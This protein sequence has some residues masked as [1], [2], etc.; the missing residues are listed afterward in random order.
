MIRLA[1]VLYTYLGCGT[2][3]NIKITKDAIKT[4]LINCT[5]SL[6]NSARYKIPNITRK[7][8]IRK[9]VY[10]L[11]LWKIWSYGFKKYTSRDE[12]TIGQGRHS[13]NTYSLPLP[14]ISRKD[15]LFMM[16][17]KVSLKRFK[18]LFRIKRLCQARTGKT[19]T[20]CGTSY[21]AI[22]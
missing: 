15:N 16:V 12:W 1:L 17:K 5:Y 2:Y 6:V 7:F 10:V 19:Q 22:K 9:A 18:F 8:S 21:C 3:M 13:L 11:K 20:E 4:I 14:H